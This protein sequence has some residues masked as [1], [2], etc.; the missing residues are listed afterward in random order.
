[1]HA[2]AIDARLALASALSDLQTARRLES[3]VDMSPEGIT[4][5]LRTQS[6]L[7]EACRKWGQSKLVLGRPLLCKG[8]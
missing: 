5:R 2:E 3:K 7:H 1:M 6:L 8:T 4:R